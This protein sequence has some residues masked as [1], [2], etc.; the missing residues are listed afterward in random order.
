MSVRRHGDGNVVHKMGI[1]RALHGKKQMESMEKKRNNV[2]TV[3]LNVDPFASELA[4]R[5]VFFGN[6]HMPTMSISRCL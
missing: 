5:I 1:Y 3:M 2:H 6:S 4:A